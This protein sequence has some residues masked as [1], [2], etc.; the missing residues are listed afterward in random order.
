ISEGSRLPQHRIKK[1]LIRHTVL[2]ENPSGHGILL[3]QKSQ[4]QMLCTDVLLP[5]SLRVLLRSGEG[6]GGKFIISLIHKISPSFL[7]LAAISFAALLCAVCLSRLHNR[8]PCL[9]GVSLTALLCA[10]LSS[11]KQPK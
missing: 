9:T 5:A 8:L 11:L 6:A 10:V 7:C 4:Y 1:C 3:G 2:R